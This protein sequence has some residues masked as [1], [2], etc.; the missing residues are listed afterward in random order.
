MAQSAAS[1]Q[2][3]G[4]DFI[5]GEVRGVN[6]QPAAGANVQLVGVTP[7]V[8]RRTQTNSAGFFVFKELPAGVYTVSA[9]ASGMRTKATS[10]AATSSDQGM[11]VKLLLQP[12][13]SDAQAMEFAD[14]PDFTVAGVTDW[15]A[16]GGHGSDASLRTSEDLARETGAMQSTT[17][18]PETRTYEQMQT[19]A[20]LRAALTKAPDSFDSNY[21]LGHLYLQQGRWQEAIPHLQAAQR[22]DAENYDN[23]SDLARAYEGAEEFAAARDQV[24][25]LLARKD[26]AELHRLAG[27]LDERLG[28]PL[29]AVEQDEQA[30]RMEPSEANYFAW[31]SE[32]LLHR[33]IRQ[34]VEVFRNGAKAHPESA[35]MLAALGA[36]LFAS[37]AYEEAALRVCDAADLNPADAQPY[38]LL[39]KIEMAAPIPLPCAE[40]KLG[41]F[42]RAEPD[43]AYANYLY[44]MALWKREALSGQAKDAATTVHAEELLTKAIELDNKCAEAYLLSGIIDADQHDYVR[45]IAAYTKAIDTNPKLSEAYYRLGV[46]YDR[47]GERDKAKH[48]F[49]LHAEIERQLAAAVESQRR[50]VKQFQVVLGKKAEATPTP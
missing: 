41:S 14:K 25:M 7:T 12:S 50:E 4:E 16:V 24:R 36:A 27:E 10:V 38:L 47:V 5:R 46:A 8:E 19:E 48:E 42:A 20:K 3:P 39:G 15:T 30:V 11:G 43:N 33:A 29:A 6:G 34:A 32:L 18:P 26:T 9:E 17:Q 21:Q 28:D 49:G 1:S 37:A 40:Q 23:A 13:V 22:A 35:R 45:A 2:K 44:A 31:G